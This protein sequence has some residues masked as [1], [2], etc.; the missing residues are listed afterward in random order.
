[1][2]WEEVILLI[3]IRCLCPKHFGVLV[4]GLVYELLRGRTLLYLFTLE[5]LLE[6]NRLWRKFLARKYYMITVA[7]HNRKKE[8][9][10]AVG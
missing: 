7:N 6:G 1:M 8:N 9:I 4:E 10:R 5:V 3:V 2:K